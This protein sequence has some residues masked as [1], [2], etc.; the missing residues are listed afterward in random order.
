MIMW[1]PGEVGAVQT[2]Q[3]SQLSPRPHDMTSSLDL[4]TPML[5]SPPFLCISNDSRQTLQAPVQHGLPPRPP[6]AREILDAS[7]W[8]VRLTWPLTSP[9]LM[10][11]KWHE[12]GMRAAHWNKI[13]VL[14]EWFPGSLPPATPWL[15]SSRAPSKSL[16][17]L[18]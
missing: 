17:S 16:L 2:Q 4:G 10:K 14:Q 9:Q 3:G 12:S 11:R 8:T 7:H 18:L 15:P 6:A 5:F 1:I 13:E